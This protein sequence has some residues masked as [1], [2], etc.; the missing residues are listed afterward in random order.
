MKQKVKIMLDV[1]EGL[2]KIHK[3]GIIHRDIKGGNIALDKE[4]KGDECDFTA[5]ILDFGVA[6]GADMSGGATTHVSGTIKYNAPEQGGGQPYDAKVDIWAFAM[7]AYE[8]LCGKE[9]FSDKKYLKVNDTKLKMMVGNKGLRP[10]K[11]DKVDDCPADVKEIYETNWDK[12]PE[13]RMTSSQLVEKLT[14]IYGAM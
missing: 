5:K 11:D 3:F 14:A 8:L 7:M 13:N 10:S 4:I 12:D 2:E 1:A 6:R 9:A